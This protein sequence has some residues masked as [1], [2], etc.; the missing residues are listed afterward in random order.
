MI[1]ENIA[2]YYFIK[3]VIDLVIA[4][5]S[6]IVLSPLLIVVS[7][8]L[9]FTGEGEVFYLQNRLGYLNSEFKIIKFATM[10]KN[11]PNIG[12]GSITVRDDPRVLPM[13]RFL[14]KSKINE[15]PQ[16][17]NVMAAMCFFF[18]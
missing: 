3:R 17:I 18:S 6:L 4:F 11:S 9:K 5:T 1:I 16:I 14:R 7:L 10:L 15:L 12:T 2:M 8:I 13:G